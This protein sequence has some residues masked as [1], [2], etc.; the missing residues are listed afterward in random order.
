MNEGEETYHRSGKHGNSL[1]GIEMGASSSGK[2]VPDLTGNASLQIGQ[3]LPGTMFVLTQK[4]I[5]AVNGGKRH[6]GY[7]LTAL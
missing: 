6:T 3:I 4:G 5:S 7:C 1:H 2:L